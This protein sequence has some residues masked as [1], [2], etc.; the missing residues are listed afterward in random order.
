MGSLTSMNVQV[1]QVGHMGAMALP[2]ESACHGPLSP[3]DEALVR[4]LCAAVA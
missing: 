2:M 1:V 4:C 3:A